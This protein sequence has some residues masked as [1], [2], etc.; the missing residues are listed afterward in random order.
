MDGSGS[1]ASSDDER[2]LLG[3]APGTSAARA[4]PSL[5]SARSVSLA[6]SVSPALSVAESECFVLIM[7][8]LPCAC[9]HECMDELHAVRGQHALRT[10]YAGRMRSSEERWIGAD[11]TTT[12]AYIQHVAPT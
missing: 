3:L 9:A 2:S 4:S 8:R 12:T 11:T 5:E 1:D 10:H 7:F 6:L